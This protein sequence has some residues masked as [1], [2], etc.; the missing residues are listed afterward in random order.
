MKDISVSA[1]FIKSF[2]K[3]SGLS[4]SDYSL[5]PLAGDG[6]KRLFKRIK[7]AGSDFT[8]IFMQ[9]PPND[10]FLKKENLA[11]LNIGNHMLSKGIPMPR[12]IRHNLEMGFF[13]LE[14]MGDTTLQDE[15][16][17]RSNRRALYE[18]VIETLLILQV[19]GRKG[20]ETSWCCQTPYY[21]ASL[22]REKEAWYFRD[23]FLRDYTRIGTDL[24]ILDKSFEHIISVAENA[25]KNFLLHRDFQS[26]NIMCLNSSIALLDWQGARLGPLAYDLASLLYDPYVDLTPDERTHLLDVY[27]SCLKVHVSDAATRFREYFPYIAVMRMLQALGAYSFLSQNQGKRYFETYI[28]VALQSLKT[29]LNEISHKQILPLINIVDDITH[30]Y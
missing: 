20:F 30:L 10:E 4:E 26:R 12:I 29:L 28:P 7:P 15:A 14:D 18:H 5:L 24:S 1:D 8:C 3:E 16:L 13:I 19:Q 11:Y 6:S 22:M 21:D 27:V 25:D 2:L 23:A 9:N 17:N